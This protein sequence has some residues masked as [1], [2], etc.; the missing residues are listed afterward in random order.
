MRLRL[1]KSKLTISR[2]AII[3]FI[4]ISVTPVIALNTYWLDSQQ[5][6]LREQ[7][8]QRQLLRTE[9]AADR[10]DNFMSQKVKALILHS[11]STSILRG[12]V[13]KARVQLRNYIKQ[14]QNIEKVEWLN[15]NG[16]TRLALEAEDTPLTQDNSF[17]TQEA[18][19]LVTFLGGKEYISPVTYIN[20]DPYTQIAVPVVTFTTAQD[21]SHLSTSEE[22]MIRSP[23]DING[24]LMVTVNLH[25]LWNT[26]FQQEADSPT[27]SYIVDSQKHLIGH[28]A[29]QFTGRR[30]DLAEQSIINDFIDASTPEEAQTTEARGINGEPVLASHAAIPTTSWSVITEEP[31][32]K[33]SQSADQVATMVW[34]LNVALVIIAIALSYVFTRRITKP[35]QKLVSGANQIGQGNL[36]TRIQLGRNDEMGTLAESINNMSGR[37]ESLVEHINTERHQLDVVLN[38]INESVF[39]LDK[40]G[41]ILLA[42]DPALGLFDVSSSQIIGTPFANIATFKRDLADVDIDVHNTDNENKTAE[43]KNV[44]FVDS[45][46]KERFVDVLV[47]RVPQTGNGENERTIQYLITVI[48]QTH[49]RELE[50]MKIDFVSMAA[51]EL[52]TP[53][54]A[55]RGY[56][57]LILNDPN[58]ELSDQFRQY[59][60]QGYESTVQLSGLINNL[61]NVSKIERNALQMSMEKLDIAKMISSNVRNQQFAAEKSQ[62]TLTYD[63][64]DSEV[65]VVGDITALREV[66]DN[67]ISNALHYT[68]ENGQ[69]T[70]GLE[71]EDDGDNVTVSVR[72]TGI[73]IPEDTVDNLFTKFYRVHGGLAT[74]SG[75]SGLGLYIS[76][77]IVESHGGTIWVESTENVGSTFSFRLPVYTEARYK[78]AQGDESGENN[79]RRE[80]GWTTKNSSS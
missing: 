65:Y 20:N 43:Y 38:S 76:K 13:D 66:V 16:G 48:D 8:E 79:V 25:Q 60:L 41:S 50:A 75:G 14:D 19:R 71:T 32:A 67:L 55:I 70:I 58:T 27:T 17:D 7:A 72:D 24:A 40:N 74:G 34:M 4:L 73:G 49:A 15:D 5:E 68:S 47:A 29:Q 36:D 44:K 78:E 56:M 30:T 45:E 35:V 54:T 62:V 26:V 59:L 22:G 61:L 57:E 2:Q 64:P 11:Q 52:R 31:L 18:F 10:A 69:V 9:A 21:F 51:H 46:D 12:D 37:I 77:S 33:V 63:G 3:L 28:P 23:E 53:L 80:H 1:P 39:A 42:N 6:V